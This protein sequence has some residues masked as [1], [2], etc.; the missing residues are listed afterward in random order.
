MV[1]AQPSTAMSC[2]AAKKFNKKKMY[3][4]TIMFVSPI[5]GNSLSIS[6]AMKIMINPVEYTQK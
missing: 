3:V 1:K 2:V 4:S 6:L 5:L